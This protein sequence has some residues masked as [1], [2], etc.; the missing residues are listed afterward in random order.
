MLHNTPVDLGKEVHQLG[1]RRHPAW[2]LPTGNTVNNGTLNT[3]YCKSSLQLARTIE[4]LNNLKGNSAVP[5]YLLP[6]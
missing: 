5:M 6:K 2:P 4:Q 3:S 1:A